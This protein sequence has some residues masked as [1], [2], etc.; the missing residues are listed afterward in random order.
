MNNLKLILKEM[1][2]TQKEL[3]KRTGIQPSDICRVAK[4]Y[5]TPWSTWIRK[6][7]EALNKE[8]EEIFPGVEPELCPYC[9][10]HGVIYIIK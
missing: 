7:S 6:I 9:E 4:G 2:I 1:G 8:P 5:Q 3:S 10:A